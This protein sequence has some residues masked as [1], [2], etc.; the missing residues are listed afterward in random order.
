MQMPRILDLLRGAWLVLFHN[1][2]PVSIIQMCEYRNMSH[3]WPTVQ[4]QA[5]Q[6]RAHQERLTALSSL[7]STYGERTFKLVRELEAAESEAKGW[8]ARYE[9]LKQHHNAAYTQGVAE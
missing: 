4:K 6:W 3:S 8:K 7:S 2:V 5:A 9:A 1:Y